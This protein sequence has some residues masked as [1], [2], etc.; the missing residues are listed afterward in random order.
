MKRILM[1]V[2]FVIAVAILIFF[3]FP[4]LM[5]K[6]ESHLKITP[7]LILKDITV[8]KESELGG[9]ELYISLSV[10]R[11]ARSTEYIRIPANPD[12]WLSR[13]ISLV[14]N[15]RLW[16]EP[17]KVGETVTIIVEL[18]EHDTSVLNPD[19]LVGIMRVKLKNKN[20]VLDFKWDK[21]N[22][23]DLRTGPDLAKNIPD[24]SSKSSGKIGI[25][26]LKNSDSHYQVQLMLT[27]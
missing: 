7:Q 14:K 18:N 20:G 5:Q 3:S 25:F 23:I 27:Q 17:L 10:R 11:P 24:L 15:A 4:S 9:D 19:D 12:H 2:F 21:L 1:G 6:I 13:K 22:E 8:I 16:S 26:D